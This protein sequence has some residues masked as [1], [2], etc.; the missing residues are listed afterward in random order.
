[1]VTFTPEELFRFAA[2]LR[3][4]ETEE[5]IDMIVENVI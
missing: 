2:K 5:K 3:T 1:M 4:N